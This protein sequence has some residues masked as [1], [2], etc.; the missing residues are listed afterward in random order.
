MCCSTRNKVLLVRRSV[1][2]GFVLCWAQ[3][4]EEAMNRQQPVRHGYFGHSLCRNVTPQFF[5]SNDHPQ[6]VFKWRSGYHYVIKLACLLVISKKTKYVSS[7][8]TC[9]I[10]LFYSGK[11]FESNLI[12]GRL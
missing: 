8:R 10:P 2:H 9:R 4:K 11:L 3:K 12:T 1:K 6:R 5:E 7:L